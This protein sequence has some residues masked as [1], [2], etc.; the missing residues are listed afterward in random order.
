MKIMVKYIIFNPPNWNWNDQDQLSN[1]PRQ[2]ILE[3]SCQTCSDTDTITVIFSPEGCT[4]ELACNYDSLATCDDASCEFVSCAG[5]SDAMACNY[6][7]TATID[8]GSCL[9]NDECGNCG[10]SDTAGCTDSTAYSGY[11]LL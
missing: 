5:C 4:D 11:N 10:G 1:N 7:A 9:E 2:Y 8:N 3:I 6:N